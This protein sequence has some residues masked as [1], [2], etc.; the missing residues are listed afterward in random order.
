MANLDTQYRT[1]LLVPALRK[2]HE[3]TKKAF[4]YSAPSNVVNLCPR[5]Y[6]YGKHIHGEYFQ[7]FS[8]LLHMSLGLWAE[9]Y[10]EKILK[11][12]KIEIV[13]REI[14]IE[15]DS[16]DLIGLDAISGR[17][18]FLIKL[19]G[20]LYFLE[21]KKMNPRRFSM[22]KT[23]GLRTE[24]AAH[25]QLLYYMYN[26]HKAMKQGLPPI[27][28]GILVGISEA[29]DI[30]DTFVEYRYEDYA[31][32]LPELKKLDAIK[33]SSLDDGF[34]PPPRPEGNTW[35]S[36]MCISCSFY[37]TCYNDQNFI[38]ENAQFTEEERTLL[39][40]VIVDLTRAKQM[41]EDA[42]KIASTTRST[43]VGFMQRKNA[44][45]LFF[46]STVGE[47][48]A[49]LKW[50]EYKELDAQKVVEADP[51][52]YEKL[53]KTIKRLDVDPKIKLSPTISSMVRGKIPN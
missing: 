43:L 19:E 7:K 15:P 38:I 2:R 24:T 48:I 25:F 47:M 13:D 50:T 41:G 51:D 37:E 32:F 18:D 17:I 34:P 36:P 6:Y 16:S 28:G 40:H 42:R 3:V 45:S 10:L 30:I 11:F 53:A 35:D 23:Q 27:E 9:D 12:V 21:V 8:G 39:N 26:W 22:F 46:N 5:A 4:S 52:L 31:K 20:K 1:P 49:E 44:H 29:P 33:H 14:V